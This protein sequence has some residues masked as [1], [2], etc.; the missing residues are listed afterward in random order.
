MTTKPRIITLGRFAVIVDGEELPTSAWGSRRSRQL[1]K[2]LVAARGWPVT[3]DE[4]ID[5]LWPDEHDPQRLGSRLSV[6]LSAVRRVL[7]GGVIADRQ[8]VR[9]DPDEVET[10]LGRLFGADT[11]DAV[12]AAYTG[13]FLPEDRY[14][15]WTAAP[16]DEALGR[17]VAA[18]RRVAGA[19]AA[20]GDHDTTARLA[21]RL[22]EADVYDTAAH[23]QL[24]TALQL[25]GE[26]AQAR[27]AHDAWRTAM[28]EL[29]IDIPDYDTFST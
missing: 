29:D 14:D 1:A 4:L 15:D 12:I 6:Q 23:E 7:K 13:E 11:D 8:A 28:A 3:R 2:R 19:A 10:D 24:V 25:A 21:R 17:F 5:M 20:T 16:R 22:I 26:P 9:L 18:A 27:R